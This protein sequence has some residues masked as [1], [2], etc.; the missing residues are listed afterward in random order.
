MLSPATSCTR[1]ARVRVCITLVVTLS[2][3]AL[4]VATAG[5]TGLLSSTIANPLGTVTAVGGSVSDLAGLS[6]VTSGSC[7]THDLTQPFLPWSDAATYYAVPA[8]AGW[9][10]AGGAGIAGG[11]SIALP[12]GASATSPE[13]CTALL[14]PEARFFQHGGGAIR[15]EAL[16]PGGL[17]LT[18]ANVQT[19]ATRAPSPPIALVANLTAV[20]AAGHSSSLRLRFTAT[21]SAASVDGVYVDP[22]KSH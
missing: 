5:A 4:N 11:G 19:T 22:Y 8:T 14:T 18:L 15:V 6:G 20:V 1:A 2:A 17:T 7:P 10:F 21:G 12:R 16:L 9:T 3:L 13:I